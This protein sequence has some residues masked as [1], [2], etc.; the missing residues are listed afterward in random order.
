MAELI[1]ETLINEPIVDA[2]V[3]IDEVEPL[4]QP[5]TTRSKC[6][7]SFGYGNRLNRHENVLHHLAVLREAG[8]PNTTEHIHGWPAKK[9]G[10]FFS[11]G[12]KEPTVRNPF[13]D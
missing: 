13:T 9:L 12:F 1:D 10:A 11:V 7:V 4:L 8:A 2:A 3:L 6:R 5:I